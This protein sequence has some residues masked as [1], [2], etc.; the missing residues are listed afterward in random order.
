MVAMVFN[1]S[2]NNV[3]TYRDRRLKGWLWLKGLASFAIACSVGAFANVG[4]S[5][6]LFKSH[7]QWILSALSGIALGAIWNY[8]ITQIYTWGKRN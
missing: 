4:I 6:Y 3:L 8:A 5:A 1:F 2:M 7:T